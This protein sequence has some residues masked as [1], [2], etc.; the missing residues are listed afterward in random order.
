MSLPVKAE[1]QRRES[2][3]YRNEWMAWSLRPKLEAAWIQLKIYEEGAI[4]LS[5]AVTFLIIAL[6][7]GVLGLSGIAGTAT[8]IAW[9]LFVV[10]LIL[11]LVSLVTGRRVP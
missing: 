4:M 6:I 1:N 5:W 11:F 7:A 8:Q 3:R 10:F 9:I 2:L